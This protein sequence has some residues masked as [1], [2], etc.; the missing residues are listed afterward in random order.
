MPFGIIYKA[1]NKENGKVYIGQTIQSLAR[2]KSNHVTDTKRSNKHFPNAIKKYGV[3]SFTW[4][5]L[6][7]C[8]SR[9]EL[10]S[11]EVFYIEKYNSREKGYNISKGGNQQSG[12]KRPDASERMK[13]NNPMFNPKSVE[14]MKKNM[15]S[16]VGKKYEEI[17]GSKKLAEKVKRKASERM[18]KNNPMKN[19]ETVRKAILSRGFKVRG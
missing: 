7:E 13:K 5:I 18:K 15:P 19:P 10:N 4:E 11:K 12:Y 9:E 1:M 6:E 14:K 2:R 3:D 8:N 16:R 17:Y